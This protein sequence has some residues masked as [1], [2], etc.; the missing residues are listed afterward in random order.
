MKLKKPKNDTEE[1]APV[2][3]PQA[4]I[5]EADLYKRSYF[6]PDVPTLELECW[7]EELSEAQLQA[8]KNADTEFKS[9]QNRL[10][11]MVKD[12]G[13]QVVYNGNQFTAYQLLGKLYLPT[14]KDLERQSADIIRSRSRSL[15]VTKE[16]PGKRGRPKKNVRNEN[17]RDYSPSP[18]RAK[19]PELKHKKKK[20][21]KKEV[22]EKEKDKD[23]D[24]DTKTKDKTL[25]PSNVH[26]V[27]TNVRPSEATAIGG[28]LTGSATKTTA[29]VDLTKEDGNKNVADSREVSFN[30]LQGKTFPSLVVVARPYLRAKDTAPPSDRSALDSKVKSVLMHTP[31]KFTEW[32]IQQGL[33]RSE[34]WCVIHAGNKLKLG[35]YSDVSK[36]PYSGG[37]V[38]ISECCPTRFV[39]VYSSSIF[40]G[41][42]FPP[43]VL[44]KLI[45]HWACQ[46]NVQNVVQWVK[47]DNLYV[48]GL[49]TWLRAICTS[50]IHQH[51][52]LLGGSGKKVE[53][54]VISL[55]TTSHD[56]T[57]RQ[58]KVEVLGVLDPVEK[59]IRLRAV[60]PLA[61][62]EKNYKKRFQKILEPL[63][64]WVHPSSVIL[65][66]L[67][68]DKGT[69]VAM[70]FK[71]VHQASSHSDQTAR[72]SNANIMEYLRRIVPRMF[73]NTL[74]LL[75]RQIIQQFLDELVWRERYGIS[76]G[77]AF[78]N[79]VIH[80]AEQSK[81]ESRD[82]ITVRLNKIAANPFKNWKYPSGGKKKEKIEL[83]PE[84]PETGRGKRG[85]KKKEPSPSPPPKK[86][87]KEKTTYIE[88]DDEEIPLAQSRKTKIK[89]EKDKPKDKKD[90]PTARSRRNNKARSYVDDDLDDIPL[91]NIKKEVRPEETVSME[92]YY[93]GQIGGNEEVKKTAIAVEC[94]VCHVEFNENFALMLHLFSHAVPDAAG[95]H[96]AQCQYCLTRFTSQEEL[97]VHLK[98]NHPADTKSPELFTYACLICEVRFAAVLTLAS[99]MQKCHCPRELPYA[100]DACDFRVS[101]HRSAADHYR[102]Q[103]SHTDTVFCPYC[104][105][106]IRIYSDGHELTA[107]LVLY[108]DHLKQHQDKDLEVRCN[109]CV[110]KFVHLGQLKEHQV[111]DHI[112]VEGATPLC[113]EEHLITKP[114][115][116]ARP[117]VKDS[118]NHTIS[119]TFEGLT[120]VLPDGVLCRECDTPLDREKHFLGTTRCTKCCS[121]PTSM[122]SETNDGH[123]PQSMA[124]R[125]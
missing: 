107:N 42:T 65:T 48:K 85:R 96:P 121:G 72:N 3:P 10:D 11:D 35:M 51:M 109:R 64:A 84:V 74:S 20:K 36:F 115:N 12:T 71:N 78:D 37:Y 90:E 49:F 98:H 118:A 106:V 15:S 83:E 117:P 7:E 119:D 52:G 99:H 87:K 68:V 1:V 26:S 94:P 113:S 32:L 28:L 47:V 88:D 103:H 31:M 59:L 108:L 2:V 13:G 120:L 14:L 110:L 39:S 57:Q 46:T 55:G 41:A 77:Q 9:I 16:K 89:E 92:R 76:P 43:S 18:E 56:G 60:E 102:T 50:A 86:R 44:L 124:K 123:K 79:I 73:Q 23:K 122:L 95:A 29:I 54:G 8:Y 101:A 91:K 112:T 111:R 104:L 67:T 22:K 5:I 125:L 45:Y 17:D 82:P 100:C 27:V 97:D 69:L 21:D 80:I 38:W 58:V 33:V 66:D 62:H 93:F 81:M 61:E 114:R 34:Q 40:E 4:E 70:G 6:G 75:S 63:S 24:K 116:K 30:K 53:V 105:K 19:T 25:A